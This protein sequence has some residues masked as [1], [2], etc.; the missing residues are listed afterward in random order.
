[1][2]VDGGY[3]DV[4]FERTKVAVGLELLQPT[5]VGVFHYEQIGDQIDQQSTCA[6]LSNHGT[7]VRR[8]RRRRRRTTS[9][10]LSIYCVEL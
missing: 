4:D 5:A 9:F 8:R 7:K 6:V 2:V 1:M 3:S 10:L